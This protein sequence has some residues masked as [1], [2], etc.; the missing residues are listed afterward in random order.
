MKIAILSDIHA[1]LEALQR[2]LEY[3][4]ENK[5]DKI[6]CLGDVVGY[7]PNPNECVDL[8]RDNCEVILMGNHDYAV[9]YEP[10]KFNVGA[11]SACYWTRQFLED[12][13]KG[14]GCHRAGRV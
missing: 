5:V 11:E 14:R 12:H 3:L 9:L 2:A 10:T 4:N 1:N 6:Y 13:A 7:G 8:V